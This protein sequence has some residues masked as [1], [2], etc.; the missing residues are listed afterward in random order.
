MYSARTGQLLTADHLF[1]HN[2]F[3][4]AKLVRNAG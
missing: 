4:I 3:R 1:A 2:S